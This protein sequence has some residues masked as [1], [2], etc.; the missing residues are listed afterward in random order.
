MED[1]LKKLKLKVSI[2]KF[3]TFHKNRVSLLKELL[4]KKV[5]GRLIF[6][7]SFLGFESLG[8]VLYPK[9]ENSKKRFL[10]ALKVINVDDAI[11]LHKY[12][13]NPLT[14]EGFVSGIWT[15][16]ETWGD[17][18]LSFASFID[19]SDTNK[20]R[21]GVE[22]PPGSILAMYEGLIRCSENYFKE[23]EIKEVVIE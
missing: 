11:I 22:Y 23:R 4:Q 21:G 20:I 1:N 7:V 14:H 15:S 9:E 3:L 6:Q 13:R 2:A 16:L 8:K 10:D 19:D 18:D 12:W 5:H 17:D